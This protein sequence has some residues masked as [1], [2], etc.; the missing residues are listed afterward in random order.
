MLKI[1]LQ[2]VPQLILTIGVQNNIIFKEIVP[3]RR[4]CNDSTLA[5]KERSEENTFVKE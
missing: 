5:S 1:Y 2:N 3:Q 4:S